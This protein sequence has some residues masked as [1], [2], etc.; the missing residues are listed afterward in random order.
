M[1]NPRHT[2]G[3]GRTE[4]LKLMVNITPSLTKS[5]LR[6]INERC[7]RFKWIYLPEI[8]LTSQYGIPKAR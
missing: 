1:L 7:F 4:G 8:Y 3:C 6:S 2:I 5:L